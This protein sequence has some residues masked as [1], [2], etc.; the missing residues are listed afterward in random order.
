ME[1]AAEKA[2]RLERAARVL[3][4]RAKESEHPM[5]TN[6]ALMLA[7]ALDPPANDNIITR[8]D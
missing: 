7:E 3:R 1:S 4:M 8:L 6:F 2:A 5:V